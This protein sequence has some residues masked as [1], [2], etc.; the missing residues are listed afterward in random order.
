MVF[1]FG[2]H[3]GQ[4]F[5]SIGFSHTLLIEIITALVST[6]KTPQTLKSSQGTTPETDL[7]RIAINK[8]LTTDGVRTIPSE[9]VAANSNGNPPQEKHYG[10]YLT[11][12]F[13][14]KPTVQKVNNRVNTA[15]FT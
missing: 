1:S 10:D 14:K 6:S 9:K 8:E 15:I 2:R 13:F 12:A 3:T 11:F 7:L 4:S 5:F